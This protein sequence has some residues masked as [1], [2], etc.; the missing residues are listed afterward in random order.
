MG[1]FLEKLA[2][3]SIATPRRSPR[4]SLANA[5]Y[6]AMSSFRAH[7]AWQRHGSGAARERMAM[8]KSFL[9]LF[10]KKEQ[11]KALLFEKRS[12]NFC[13]FALATNSGA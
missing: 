10:F 13:S 3:D 8:N 1:S 5:A 11:E 9:V 6:I 4:F 12:K 7:V 2:S